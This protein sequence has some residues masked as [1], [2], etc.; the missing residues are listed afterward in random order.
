LQPE[1]RADL[2]GVSAMDDLH[3][4][5]QAETEKLRS[6]IE[7]QF[8]KQT[9]LLHDMMKSSMQ[10]SA[11]GTRIPT[12]GTGK[13]SDAITSLQLPLPEMETESPRSRREQSSVSCTS[14]LEPACGDNDTLSDQS[15][16]MHSVGSASPTNP[17]QDP[18]ADEHK[19]H[20][21]YQTPTKPAS[22][23]SL[24]R[25]M[26]AQSSLDVDVMGIHRRLTISTAETLGPRPWVAQIATSHTFTM[27]IMCLIILNLILMGVEVEV[28]T[29]LGAEDIPPWFMVINL[30]IVAVFVLEIVLK[31]VGL[32]IVG[33]FCGSDFRWNRLDFLIV[34]VSAGEIVLELWSAA[35]GGANASH[36]RIVRTMRIARALR[37]IRVMRL[38]RYVSALRTLMLSIIST[39]GSLFWTLLLLILLF[40][41]FAVILTQTVSDYCRDQQVKATGD[42]NALPFCIDPALLQFWPSV[43]ESML[44]LF[45]SISGGID[46]Q[47]AMEPLRE[48]SPAAVIMMIL[49]IVVAVFAVLNVVTGVFCTTAIES[50][51]SD[52]D[53]AIMKQMHKQRSLVE[54]L[55]MTFSEIDHDNSNRVSL[56]ELKQALTAK[57]LVHFMESLGIS[58]QDVMT[59]F[60]IIDHDESG[61]IDLDEFVSGCMQLH[62]PAKS[63]QMAQVFHELHLQRNGIQSVADS[64]ADLQQGLAVKA[65]RQ[66]AATS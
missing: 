12:A 2:D 43:L 45:L 15:K 30:L 35:I 34:V 1:F 9:A 27:V 62:G 55:K 17:D 64:V 13:T 28:S 49:F 57:K 33:F 19:L 60:L 37:G 22:P 16:V 41:S 52:K 61:W 46:W 20:S 63:L 56:D 5:L 51:Q 59:L 26:S 54:A 36:L 58:T 11:G 23:R 42:P 38:F 31:M 53:I 47:Q 6:F 29:N 66:K 10:S 4:Q 25:G 32:G 39:A 3:A 40:Y 21:A 18:P 8:S 44:T 50:A 65:V 14:Q 7:G 48:V 24:S